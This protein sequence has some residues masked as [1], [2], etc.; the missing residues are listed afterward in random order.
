MKD[1]IIVGAGHL[2]LDVYALINEIN[3]IKPT[4]NIKG[5]LN[6]FPVD[7]EQFCINEKIIGTI[8]E[9]MP[10]EDEHFALAIGS[11]VEK[12]KIVNLFYEKG[13]RFETL[14]SPRA[15]I[16]KSAVIGEGSIIMSS[17]SIGTCAKIGKYTVIGHTIVSFNSSVGDY[18]NTASYV[19]IYR[20]ISVGKRVQIW[21]HSAILNNVGD[22][23]IVGAGS[24]VVAKVKAGTKVFGNP[25]KRVNF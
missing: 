10:K 21:T 7:L 16:A 17:S 25:A 12:E 11:P 19:N 8:H 23:A 20:N 18:S 13:G 15:V 3:N 5:F 14:I 24:V 9:W 4:W 1:I 2:S 6:D 22:D